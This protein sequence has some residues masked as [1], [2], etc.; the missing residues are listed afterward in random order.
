MLLLNKQCKYCPSCDL[1]ITKQSE[2]KHLLT[3][4]FSQINSEIIGNN[5]LVMGTAEK[6]VWKERNKQQMEPS[7]IIERMYAFNDVLKFNVIPA[8]WYPES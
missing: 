5:Y 2:L 4:S 7:E 8:G 6:K 1:I 3:T